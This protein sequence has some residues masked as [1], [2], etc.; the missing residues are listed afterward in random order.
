MSA[1]LVR[2]VEHVKRPVVFLGLVF[3]R[4]RMGK[5]ALAGADQAESTP[6]GQKQE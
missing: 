3:W 4:V 6:Q 5:G 2:H 1:C